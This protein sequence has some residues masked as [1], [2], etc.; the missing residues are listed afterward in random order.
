MDADEIFEDKF[1]RDIQHLLTQGDYDLYS[2]RLYDFWNDTHYREDDYWRSHFYYRPFLVRYRDDFSYTWKE[3]PQHC[4]RFS[5]NIFQLPNSIS[6]L[7]V[8]HYG[9]SKLEYRLEKYKRY[10]TL[11]PHGQYGMKGQY[12]SILDENPNLIKWE[13]QG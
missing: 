9:W 13:E 4:G 11:D 6:N 3:T 12:D 5:N 7:R 1:D 2:F 8:K 10:L